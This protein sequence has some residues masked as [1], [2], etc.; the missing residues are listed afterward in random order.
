MTYRNRLALL[1]LL[2]LLLLVLAPAPVCAQ[3]PGVSITVDRHLNRH[4]ISPDIYGTA[5]GDPPGAL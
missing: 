1:T 5:Y 4:P 2:S 3:N